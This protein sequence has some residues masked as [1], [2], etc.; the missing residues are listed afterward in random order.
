MNS[1]SHTRTTGTEDV[2]GKCDILALW[3]SKKKVR[4]YK[5]N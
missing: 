3:N 1:P 2:V 5:E 4:D